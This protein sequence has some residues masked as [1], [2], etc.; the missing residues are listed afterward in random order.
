MNS[1]IHWRL[2]LKLKVTIY[3][4][5]DNATAVGLGGWARL[6]GIVTSHN[7]Q[8]F[9]KRESE[10]QSRQLLHR[11]RTLQVAVD[12]QAFIQDT[13]RSAMNHIVLGPKDRLIRRAIRILGSYELDDVVGKFIRPEESSFEV[14]SVDLHRSY[15]NRQ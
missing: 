3:V 2:T 10:A 1:A 12:L 5:S 9:S 13:E 15:H 6:H 8:P 14:A 4:S 11:G 7:I